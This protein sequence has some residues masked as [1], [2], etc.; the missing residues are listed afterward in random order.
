MISVGRP[1]FNPADDPSEH[2]T[3][4]LEGVTW[5]HVIIRDFGRKQV[6][7]RHD[8]FGK[9]TIHNW[10]RRPN[11][12]AH[13]IIPVVP[14][15]SGG[16]DRV[17]KLTRF[18]AKWMKSHPS[19]DQ[20][21]Y[22]KARIKFTRTKGLILEAIFYPVNDASAHQLRGEFAVMIVD[23][24]KR[25]NICL[26]PAEIRNSSAWHDD[27][28]NHWENVDLSDLNPSP[29]FTERVSFKPKSA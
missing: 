4:F 25:L 8:E 6:F 26:L 23:A 17:L 15:L 7:I 14:E 24:A 11:K 28:N 5:G 1:G 12:G 21:L 13:F 20:S 29:E 18:A 3:G 10:T 2:L 16:S 27:S 9:L 19:V 22:Q